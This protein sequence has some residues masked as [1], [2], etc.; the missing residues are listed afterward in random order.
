[1]TKKLSEK[2]IALIAEHLQTE[3]LKRGILAP[4]TKIEEEESRPGKTHISFETEEFQTT[5]VI[6]KSLKVE[7]FNSWIEEVDGGF[8]IGIDVHY[9][10]KHFGGGSNGCSLFKFRCMVSEDGMYVGSVVCF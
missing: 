7:N 10:Y 3:L 8:Q 9:S 2:A 1:M 4:I 6:F 5:P